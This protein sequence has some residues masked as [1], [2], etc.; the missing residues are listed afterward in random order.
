MSVQRTDFVPD[1]TR[2]TLVG[3][4]L[5]SPQP[6]TVPVA[7]DAH[8]EL[9]SAYPWGW[10]TPNAGTFNLQDTGSYAGGALRLPGHRHPTGRQREP[11]TT[12][13]PWSP[14]DRPPSSHELGPDHRGPQDPA[15]VCPADGPAPTTCDDGAFGKGT[16]GQLR[17]QVRLTPNQPTTLWFAV[18]G[19]D[20]GVG[21][22]RAQL[23]KA[24]ADP[25]D[26]L[27]AEGR[28]AAADR[29]P[30]HRRPAR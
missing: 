27:G 29:V 10:T 11:S 2:A 15:V 16:G 13:R 14:A 22:A 4:T 21:A 28:R 24:L 23:T 12:G 18:A 25:A 6:R 8:S 9:M 30:H 17:W 7:M 3:L 19:S 1:G 5:T 26:A 20:Q